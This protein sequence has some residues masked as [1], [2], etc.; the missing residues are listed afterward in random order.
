MRFHE[1]GSYWIIA[2]SIATC[3]GQSM[4]LEHSIVRGNL[5]KSDIAVPS[6]TCKTAD[7]AQLMCETTPLL[8]LLA[9]DNR[10]LISKLTALFSQWVNM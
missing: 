10:D 1:T 3:L 9:R 8:L 5:F 4:D 6:C 2:Y 7:V